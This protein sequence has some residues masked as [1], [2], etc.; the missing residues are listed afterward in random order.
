MTEA[1]AEKAMQYLQ[2]VY[3]GIGEKVGKLQ[4]QWW[5]ESDGETYICFMED[6]IA[7]DWEGVMVIVRA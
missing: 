1:A 5:Y 3:P 6:P 4:V 2:E 7:Q